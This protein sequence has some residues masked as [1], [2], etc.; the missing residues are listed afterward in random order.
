MQSSLESARNLQQVLTVLLKTVLEN[1]AEVSA[2]SELTVQTVT[3]RAASEMG[4]VI[5]ALTAAVAS[6][7][8]LQSQIVSKLH[9]RLG[10]QTVFLTGDTGPIQGAGRGTCTPPGEV[11]DGKPPYLDLKSSTDKRQGMGRLANLTDDLSSKYQ[12]HSE[13]L[14]EAQE[15]TTNILDTLEEASK[16][17]T[18]MRSAIYDHS[19]L[20]GWLLYV[21]CPAAS[22]VMGSYGLKPSAIRNLA[23]VALG[24]YNIPLCLRSKVANII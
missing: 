22:L 11:G 7:A 2:S 23:L 6:S 4:I 13:H 5:T 16:S 20:A 14:D 18:T 12:S 21:V 10:I 19:G 9:V 1:N 3:Q 8:S 15:R 17:V 24:R